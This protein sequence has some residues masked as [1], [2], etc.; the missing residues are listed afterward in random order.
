MLVANARL[1][2]ADQGPEVVLVIHY[3]V[4]ERRVYVAGSASATEHVAIE[5]MVW[6]SGARFVPI[7]HNRVLILRHR[8]LTQRIHFIDQFRY[9]IAGGRAFRHVADDV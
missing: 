2:L 7:G 4:A 9:W 3:H 5:L 6:R 8:R 1:H